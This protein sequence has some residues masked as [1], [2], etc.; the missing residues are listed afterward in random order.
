MSGRKILKPQRFLYDA[1]GVEFDILYMVAESTAVCVRRIIRRLY[2][3]NNRSEFSVNRFAV[4]TFYYTC[5][6]YVVYGKFLTFAQ[7]CIELEGSNCG[8]IILFLVFRALVTLNQLGA[9]N[10]TF[11]FCVKRVKCLTCFRSIYYIENNCF[12]LLYNYLDLLCIYYQFRI[13]IF[14]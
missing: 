11:G 7:F 8:S 4:D 5:P 14:L 9:L 10:W 1:V 3:R 6:I 13:S 2:S 12:H